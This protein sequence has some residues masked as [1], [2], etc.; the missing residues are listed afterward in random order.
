LLTTD[1]KF[2]FTPM[3]IV[4]YVAEL[5]QFHKEVG[6]DG[7]GTIYK[8][9]SPGR[10][11]AESRSFLPPGAITAFKKEVTDSS[12]LINYIVKQENVSREVAAD[13]LSRFA[14]QLTHSLAEKGYAALD[15]I[16]VLR[17]SNGNIFL[18]PHA[19]FKPG[20]EFF[21]LPKI[22]EPITAIHAMETPETTMPVSESRVEDLPAAEIAV[23]DSPAEE[24]PVDKPLVPETPAEK[25][26]VPE[27]PVIEEPVV[28]EPDEVPVTVIP[29]TP[30]IPV[31]IPVTISAVEEEVASEEE[32]IDDNLLEEENPGKETHEPILTEVSQPDFLNK[33]PLAADN[34]IKY[35]IRED[36]PKAKEG[37]PLITKVAL[38]LL[39][40]LL[41][42]IAFYYL[43]P[44]FS[45]SD[46]AETTLP[47]ANAAKLKT[48]SIQGAQRE[49]AML[50]SA[51]K[52]DS[53][54][55]AAS[56]QTT[57]APIVKDSVKN[58][59]P[60]DTAVT[61]EVIGAS[62]LNEKEAS[63]FIETMK[64]NGIRAKVVHSIP[65]KRLKLSI[66]TL[67]DEQ[68]AKA[69]RD[70]LGEKLK[71]KGLYIYKNK[72]Q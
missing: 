36:A 18:E 6:I 57:A 13:Q 23:T 45:T 65:G 9:K 67:K 39:G 48:D 11:D 50:D 22:T 31:T 14:I 51:F 46:T 53:A 16:G 8:K 21:G 64:K 40:I 49:Q 3:E 33:S 42:S 44:R 71:I 62:V 58:V 35:T 1:L 70:R 2:I 7:F 72:P 66:A 34:N 12:L 4:K 63:W 28:D 17:V 52:A 59:L 37:G 54:R 43:Y 68:T 24:V 20:T 29:A 25:V 15:P 47:Q 55:I 69:E 10:Y 19:D 32:I 26:I 30:V 38:I 60:A 56:K 5:I 27:P 61:Y 41:L